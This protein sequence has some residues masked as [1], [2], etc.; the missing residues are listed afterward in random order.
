M[1][2]KIFT[3]ESFNTLI[4]E[5]KAYI[6]AAVSGKANTEH[7][8]ESFDELP[9]GIAKLSDFNMIDTVSGNLVVSENC[10]STT[11]RQL[12]IYGKSTQNTTT[13]AQLLN[14][15]EGTF[16]NYG[17]TTTVNDNQIVCTGTSTQAGGIFLMGNGYTG[18]NVVLSLKAGNYT[19][20]GLP[21]NTLLILY[22]ADGYTSNL[23]FTKNGTV[24]L[25]NDTD[26]TSVSLRYES[27]AVMDGKSYKI[28]FNA[29]DTALPWEPYTGG[30]AS[31]NPEYPQEIDVAGSDGDI[32]V[33]V[34]GANF[35]NT[36]ELTTRTNN[37][38]TF[39]PV[40]DA[41][42]NLEYVEANGTNTSDSSYAI[43]SIPITKLEIGEKYTMSGCPVGGSTSTHMMQ[44][45]YFGNEFGNGTT[46][47]VTEKT[48]SVMNILVTKGY[49]VSN[50]RFYPMLNIGETVHPYEP[51]TKQSFT[52]STQNGLPG[53][54][55]DAGGNYT[56]ADGQQYIAD[57]IRL[58]SDGTGKW[59]HRVGKLKGTQFSYQ[60]NS[61]RWV[62]NAIDVVKDAFETSGYKE[63]MC[64]V[65]RFESTSKE[66]TC[67]PGELELAHVQIIYAPEN[68]NMSNVKYYYQCEPYE[69]DLSADEVQAFLNLRMNPTT[70]IMNDADCFM[71]VEYYVNNT[72]NEV[73][74]V[75]IEH[76]TDHDD[77]HNVI[78][79][80]QEQINNLSVELTQAEYNAL[81]AAG[82]T[83]PE[84]VYYITDA[85]PESGSGAS[86]ADKVSYDNTESGL[87]ATDLQG[88]MDEVTAEIDEIKQSFQDGCDTIAGECTTCGVSPASNSPDDIATAIEKIY[89]IR[90]SEGASSSKATIAN[91]ATAKSGTQTFNIKSLYPDDYTKFTANDF[92]VVATGASA[93]SS[94]ANVG[95]TSAGA[96]HTGVGN[97][98][99]TK[100]YNNSTGVLTVTAPDV[101]ISTPTTGIY[102]YSD[103]GYT[104]VR[105]Y[106]TVKFVYSVYIAYEGSASSTDTELNYI[107]TWISLGS[108][109]SSS[110]RTIDVSSYEGYKDF[111]VDNFR[112]V[113]KGL[114]VVE[115]TLSYGGNGELSYDASTGK[116]TIG[117]HVARHVCQNTAEIRFYYSYEVFI[118]QGALV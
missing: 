16:T 111:T 63:V 56:D 23:T 17:V 79:V 67:R 13:G 5:I 29:G 45:A 80:I 15:A 110:A 114:T 88:A 54:P 107:P 85:D 37:G 48:A 70:T 92:Y 69:T 3:T 104:Y 95:K 49:T 41:V 57:E 22:K 40:Y 101:S 26:F 28:M 99:I 38:V 66:G 73:N 86:N 91:I 35:A 44:I 105:G 58:N 36:K 75:I 19:L 14:S 65:A 11:P 71:D 1:A 94:S 6:T 62:C 10:V 53:I 68:T 93:T 31:P 43:Y 60:S 20:Q 59:M 109:N 83:D 72:E 108:Y 51:Y 115:G 12:S 24:T 78:P 106:A 64:N 32:A 34:L 50:L 113:N 42:G 39:T 102:P 116:L 52:L 61:S 2:R 76:I 30:K 47:I 25:A 8:H 90:Y 82:E 97:N 96:S 89:Q 98:T 27:G 84:T 112:V 103:D 74:Q 100:S 77:P 9:E 21:T 33:D 55:V 87:E 117:N 18:T 46:A 81:E 118:L 4:S 7:K